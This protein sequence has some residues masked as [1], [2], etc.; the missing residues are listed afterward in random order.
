M[1]SF[2]K[3]YYESATELENSLD[4]N[5][6]LISE[7]KTESNKF[8]KFS[9]D[10]VDIG[11]IYYSVGLEPQLVL[12]THSNKIFLGI[13][14]IYACL[15]YTA[16]S[17][18]FEK[19]LPSLLYEILSDLDS[20]YII[21]V[22]ELDIVIYNSNG[23]FLWKIGFRDTIENYYIEGNGAIVIEC[24]DGDKTTF[25]LNTGKVVC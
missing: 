3:T 5:A 9:N 16:K 11:F 15:D 24:S 19:E 4:K 10:L 23:L 18:L 14:N 2:E 7:E 6:F 21:Y 8:I 20:K 17:L 13:N 1:V 22:C 12:L 25:S